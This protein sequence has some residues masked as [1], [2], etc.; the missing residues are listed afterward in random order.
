MKRRDFLRAASVPA[1][2]ATASAA[3]GVG[4]AQE[5]GNST[6]SGTGTATGTGTG[7]GTGNGTA[8]GGGGGGGGPTKTVTVGP[9]NDLVF[10]P[11][12]GEPLEIAPGT[13]VEFVWDSN[14]HNIVVES[15]PDGANWQG[16]EPIENE[17]FTYTHTFETLGEYSY[18]CQPHKSAG[19]VGTI[20]VTENPGGGEGSGEKELH[21]LGVP[22][23]AHW[24]GSATIL[25]IIVSAIFT[26]YILKYGESP[27]TGTG[28]NG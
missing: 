28:R 19:M 4:A 26:F 20:V 13:T 24:V 15:Q 6:S 27:N 14:N 17:G 2:T 9:G 8:T 16:H 22:I 23:Q 11:G 21:E 3:A 25:G 1:A 12:T 7:T 18:F 5:T 10:S